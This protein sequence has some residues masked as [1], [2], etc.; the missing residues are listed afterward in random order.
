MHLF[1]IKWLL[2]YKMKNMTHA[3]NF[4][5]LKWGSQNV[6][7]VQNPQMILFT[8]TALALLAERNNC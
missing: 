8:L 2:V 1:L 4:Q 3:P 6:L 5:V 7:L